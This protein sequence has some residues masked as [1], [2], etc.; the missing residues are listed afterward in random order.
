M[1]VYIKTVVIL[2]TLLCKITLNEK[3]FHSEIFILSED[4]D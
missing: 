1:T 4:M 3:S 2:Y